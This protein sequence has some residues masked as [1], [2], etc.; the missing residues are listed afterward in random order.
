MNTVTRPAPARTPGTP[1]PLPSWSVGAK[2]ILPGT[3]CPEHMCAT[4]SHA[5]GPRNAPRK[6]NLM[7]DSQ[8]ASPRTSLAAVRDGPARLSPE[9]LAS[10]PRPTRLG[11]GDPGPRPHTLMMSTVF[12]CSRGSPFS[13]HLHP[14][15]HPSPHLELGRA[16]GRGKLRQVAW[17][18]QPPGSREASEPSS[19]RRRPSVELC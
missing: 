8:R 12:P 17:R 19:R 1:R 9:G 3:R 5:E 14:S 15:P 4:H 16:Q 2:C 11:H 7:S 18:S 13:S 10:A 6:G